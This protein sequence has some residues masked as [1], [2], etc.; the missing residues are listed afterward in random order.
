MASR[1]ARPR[2]ALSLVAFAGV[3]HAQLTF[4]GGNNQVVR[5]E[6]IYSPMR[7][8]HTNGAGNPFAGVVPGVVLVGLSSMLVT[9][10][11]T[12]ERAI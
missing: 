4:G 1:S 12:L 7:R 9:K 3:A 5:T 2:R 11:K 10:K 6:T 8:A